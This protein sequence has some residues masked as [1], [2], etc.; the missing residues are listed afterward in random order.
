MLCERRPRSSHWLELPPPADLERNLP[1]HAISKWARGTVR[2]ISTLIDTE[3][4]GGNGAVGLTWHA[5]ISRLGKRPK[6]RDVDHFLR[7]FELVG[8]DEDNHHPGGVRNFFMPVDP[9]YRRQCE[10]KT[11]EA[12]IVERDGFTWTNPHDVTQGACRG[13]ELEQMRGWP[14]PIHGREQSRP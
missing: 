12:T 7:D 11:T 9:A 8:A 1:L 5:T 6:A 4:P 2:V 10:C 14:C 3:L 13:C